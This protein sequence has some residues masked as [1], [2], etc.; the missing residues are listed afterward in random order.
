MAD[1][2]IVLPNIAKTKILT[3]ILSDPSRLVKVVQV[4]ERF[5]VKVG[6]SI[7]PLEAENMEFM[8]TPGN[9]P[10]PKIVSKYIREA[11]NKLRHIP[12]QG[13][14]GNWNH[15]PYYKGILS[16]LNHDLSISGPFNNKELLY[17]ALLKC[18][19]QKESPHYVR[20]LREPIRHYYNLMVYCQR[21]PDWLELVPDIFNE[22]PVEYLMMRIFYISMFY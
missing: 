11:L 10:I 6:A 20:L 18:L 12:S 13:Y 19:G 5:M 2:G 9:I 16:T 21:K 14:F 15:T 7:Q 3:N 4:R 22:Y 17:Q 8:A 1:E